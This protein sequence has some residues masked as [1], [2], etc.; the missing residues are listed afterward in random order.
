[1]NFDKPMI[2]LVREIR[3][4]A[5]SDFKPNIKLANPE[6]LNG[7]LEIHRSSNDTVTKTLIKELFVMAGSP[8]P[9]ALKESQAPDESFIT[10]VYRGQTQLVAVPKEKTQ[11]P[12]KPQ[13]IYRGQPVLG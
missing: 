10:K 1:M 7:L 5:P 11:K 8:W 13:K 4:R 12:E 2:D 9:E 6:L 3:R